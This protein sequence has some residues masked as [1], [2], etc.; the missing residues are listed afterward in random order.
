M[1]L[2]LQSKLLRSLQEGTIDPVGS[3]KNIKVDVRVVAATNRNLLEEVHLKNFRQDLYYRLS[4][5]PIHLPPLRKRKEDIPLLVR[6]FLEEYRV[7]FNKKNLSISSTGM[8]QLLNYHW[9]GNVRELRGVIERSLVFCQENIIDQIFIDSSKTD[10]IKP[11]LKLKI[12]SNDPTSNKP[13]ENVLAKMINQFA[14]EKE[15]YTLKDFRDFFEKEIIRQFLLNRKGVQVQVAK[16]LGLS[17]E[18]LKKRIK[19]LGI[20]IY[21]HN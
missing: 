15:N 10:L 2:P 3:E 21:K 6:H 13:V 11:P 4:I 12:K 19:M 5:L 17:R 1:P 18:T 9:P 20:D 16:D 14:Q 7:K 8:G